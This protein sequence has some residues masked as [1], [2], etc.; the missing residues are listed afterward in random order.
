MSDDCLTP[1]GLNEQVLNAA[2]EAGVIDKIQAEIGRVMERLQRAG[3][4]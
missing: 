3:K 2:S 1:G 4:P